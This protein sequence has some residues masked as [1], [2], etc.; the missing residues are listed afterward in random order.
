MF[1][2]SLKGN[3]LAKRS[4][5]TETQISDFRNGKNLRMDSVEKILKALSP[6][7]RE[8]MLILVLREDN[9]GI[10]PLPKPQNGE[11]QGPLTNGV[12]K[13]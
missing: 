13:K 9:A 12:D 11:E 2:F 1:R 4:G 7:A 3:E 5:L 10:M 6:E 8:Y